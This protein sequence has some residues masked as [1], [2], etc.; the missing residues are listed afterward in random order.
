MRHSKPTKE[1]NAGRAIRKAAQVL[2][3]RTWVQG[4]LGSPNS[5]MCV[6]GVIIFAHTGRTLSIINAASTSIYS[7]CVDAEHMF[8]EWLVINRFSDTSDIPSWN[9]A[10]G[11]TKEEVLLYMNKFADEMDSQRP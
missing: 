7:T 11:R 2:A 4:A 5:A 8:G 1:Q 6:R 10:K 9:D 3:D